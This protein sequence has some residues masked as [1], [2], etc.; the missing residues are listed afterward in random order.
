MQEVWIIV[1]QQFARLQTTVEEARKGMADVLEGE[2]LQ[3]LRQAE[4]IQAHLEQRRTEL[5]K[6]VTQISKL[7]RS[8]SDVDFLQVQNKIRKN[9][10][11]VWNHLSQTSHLIWD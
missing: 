5:M 6:T 4:S 10:Q 7:S 9:A 2:K 8:K 11:K 3:A 1:E